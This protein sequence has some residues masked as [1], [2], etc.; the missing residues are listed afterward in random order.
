M[1]RALAIA[2]CLVALL[3]G[4]STAEAAIAKGKFAGKTKAGDPLGFRVD[5]SNRVYSFYFV[6][7]TLKCTDGESFDTPSPESPSDP[8]PDTSGEPGEGDREIRTPKSVRFVIDANNKWG[9]KASNTQAG[10]GYSAKGKFSS[11]DKSTGTFSIFANFR[12]GGPGQIDEP[13]PNGEIKCSSGTL[14]FTVK[15]K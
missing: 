10:N 5:K 9:F 8:D 13:D 3:A 12:E 1:K 15:R 6:G 14:K 11:Q 2:A 7:V 4:V